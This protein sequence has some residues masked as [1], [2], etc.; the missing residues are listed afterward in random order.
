MNKRNQQNLLLEFIDSTI[1]AEIFE[2]D[3]SSLFQKFLRDKFHKI[4]NTFQQDAPQS[5]RPFRNYDK[6]SSFFDFR[7]KDEDDEFILLI[8]KL[9]ELDDKEKERRKKLKED[10]AKK[11]ENYRKQAINNTISGTTSLLGTMSQLYKGS[12]KKGEQNVDAPKPLLTILNKWI[13]IN[14]NDYLLHDIKGQPLSAI[15]MTQR[16]NKIFGK[17]ASIKIG[18]AHV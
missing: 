16:L 1:Q 18:R 4:K 5:E 7:K 10:E 2:K 12:A 14:D 6:K 8:K 11:Q 17:H 9:K 3:R 13:T 15:K